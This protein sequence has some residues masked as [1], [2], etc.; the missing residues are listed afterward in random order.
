VNET[1][2][3]DSS[4][5]K[6][7]LVE[8]REAK[9]QEDKERTKWLD[10]EVLAK[11]KLEVLFGRG[12]SASGAI[13]GALTF[14]ESGTALHGGGDTAM[15]VCP[16]KSKGV[17]DCDA[18]IPDTA[19]GIGFLVCPKC[20]RQW[21]PED[22]HGQLLL[23]LPLSKWADVVYRYFV[24]LEGRV[25]LVLKYYPESL[26]TVAHAEQEKQLH[27]ERFGTVRGKRS[28]LVYP[29]KNLIKDTSAG[30]S[31]HSRILAWLRA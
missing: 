6:D 10:G 20:Q 23:R 1:Y 4:T 2:S 19:H 28:I 27:G 8:H 13:A 3:I 11:Y 22:V 16:G 21:R 18:F 14:W 7:V 17:N 12:R 9:A 29:M 31:A 30:A 15:H 24:Q 5:A 26:I 25:D